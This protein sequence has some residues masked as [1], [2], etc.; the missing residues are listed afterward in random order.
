MDSPAF[1]EAVYSEPPRILGVKLRPL[2][3]GHKLLLRRF[4]PIECTPGSLAL[5]VVICS[6]TY[7]EALADITGNLPSLL[8]RFCFRITHG[9]WWKLWVRTH[10]DW[11]SQW[12]QFCDYVESSNSCPGFQVLSSK[13]VEPSSVPEIQAVK[14]SLM[15]HLH[16]T[17]DEF[18]DRPWLL[19]M[20]DYTVLNEQ[21]G[22]VR[23]L[24]DD[25]AEKYA[26]AQQAGD[27]FFASQEGKDLM[28]SH[29]RNAGG[30]DG[31]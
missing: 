26:T 30:N 27:D 28:E 1:I 23:L 16:I 10:V 15:R 22:V 21:L 17:E 8:D 3:A 6:Q 4:V 19:S 29:L 2:S 13:E 14:V 20:W 5:S 12:V 7:E 24:P 25:H 11:A 31:L 18:L 9:P